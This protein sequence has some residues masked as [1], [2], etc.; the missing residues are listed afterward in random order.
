VRIGILE[1]LEA[2]Y[3][4]EADRFGQLAVS[5][6]AKALMSIFLASRE[7]KKETGV[8]D[9]SVRAHSV[10]KI[11]MLGGG[12]M[13][14]GIAVVSAREA[15]V[16]VRIKEIDDA[17]ILRGL[18][19][20]RKVLDG[21]VKRR[22]L[23]P[24]AADRL[25]SFVTASTDFTGWRSVDLVVEAVFED[26]EIKRKVLKEVEEA[27][28]PETIFASNT[29]SIPITQI[30]EA[31]A[32][33]ETVIGMHYFSPVEKMPLVEII[34]T[35]QTAPWVTATCVSLGKAQGKTVIVVNDG[36]G[37]YTSRIIS[38]YMNEAAWLLTEGASIEALD[39]ALMDFGFPVGPLTLL[40]EVGIDVAGKV[41]HIL[42]AQFGERM[43]A[44]P[45][46]QALHKDE[47]RGRKNGRGFYHYEAGKKCGVDATVYQLLGESAGRRS[48]K[49]EEI[50][51][52]LAL[53]MCNE[54]A[55]CLEEGILHSARDGDVGAIFGLGFPPFLGGPFT[56][57]DTLGASSVVSELE[58]YAKK[59]GPRFEPAQ[60]LRERARAG[61]KF[62]S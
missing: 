10:A 20:V 54:A 19:Y 22:R 40:D 36:T 3:A 25:M 39:G 26:L 46:I 43:R 49:K 2:G 62:R 56:Y 61:A 13:G 18:R 57:M 50:Q 33:P 15:G 45:A 12:L 41:A 60:I 31:S 44:P 24:N 17:G 58:A 7:L 42:D 29:S 35:E 8:S 47:R 48:F 11:G 30:A 52:R 6:Q 14:G 27:T 38:P 9:A 51:K 37:F 16:P 1:G 55:R 4:A 32:H 28:S 23:M 53:M 21:D 34:T 59:H 5:S